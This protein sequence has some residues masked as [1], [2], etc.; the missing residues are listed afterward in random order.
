METQQKK[1]LSFLKT[2]KRITSLEASQKLHITSLHKTLY[3][4]RKK[5]V[6]IDDG[7]WE[8]NPNTNV[9]FKSYGLSKN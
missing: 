7:K 2:G 1:L 8:I 4:M 6:K 9:R 5:G 3:L